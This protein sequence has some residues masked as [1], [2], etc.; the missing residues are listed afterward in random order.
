MKR[1][2]SAPVDFWSLGIVAYELLFGKRPFRGKTN[3]ALTNA[4][5]HD[6]LLW[7]EDAP[8]RCSTEGMQA[9]RAVSYSRAVA[10][11]DFDSFLSVIQT[12]A[13]DGGQEAEASKTLGST[14]GSMVSTGR[15]STTNRLCRRLSPT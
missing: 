6:P 2:Y 7:P 14:P 1:G 9:I 11:T 4:I 15:Q 13:L 5:L 3:T 10:G 12:S 8:G